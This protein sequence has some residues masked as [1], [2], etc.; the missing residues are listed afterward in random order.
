MRFESAYMAD[1]QSFFLGMDTVLHERYRLNI[2]ID[3][4]D[5]KRKSW[6]K[7]KLWETVEK[8]PFRITILE[9]YMDWQSRPRFLTKTG[10]LLGIK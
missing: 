1:S 2:F 8:V 6:Y 10:F 9:E 5:S 4:I 3:I 7:T